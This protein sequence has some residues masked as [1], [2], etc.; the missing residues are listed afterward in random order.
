M[1]ALTRVVRLPRIFYGWWIVAAGTFTQFLT[2]GLYYYG[3]STL[4]L[5]LEQEFGWSRAAVSGVVSL[6]RLEGG[7]TGPVGGY[8]VDRYGP[9]LVVLISVILMGLGFIALSQ[10]QSLIVFYA[11]YIM[12]VAMGASTGIAM[13]MPTAVANWFIRKRSR[14]MGILYAG[15]GLGGAAVPVLALLISAYGWRTALILIGVLVI[16]V[17]VPLSLVFRQRPEQYG[18]SPDGE[19]P[20]TSATT[21]APDEKKSKDAEIDFTPGQALRTPSFWLISIAFAMR[22]TASHGVPLHLMPHLQGQGFST[23]AAALALGALG[24]VS[25]TGRLGFSWLGDF[26]EKRLVLFG[27]T[28][29]MSVGLLFL[30]LPA[31]WTTVA[32]FLLIYAPGYGGA[33]PLTR[34]IFGEYYGRKHYG[35]ISGY[36]ALIIIAGT[37]GG[38]LFAGYMYDTSKSYT[39]AFYAFAVANTLGAGLIF[40]AKRPKPPVAASQARA[41]LAT[42]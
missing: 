16:A 6:S 42:G 38:P 18:M 2:G 4:V 10:V 13:A 37:V 5:P 3:F 40:L 23:E 12:F 30:N 31:T 15:V 33:P 19:S 36:F 34:A 7:L 35:T 26:W 24:V 41:G 39:I 17:F 22:T 21:V 32:L 14:A 25:V 20:A 29:L 8:L 9:R 1:R 28:M 11:I 27:S